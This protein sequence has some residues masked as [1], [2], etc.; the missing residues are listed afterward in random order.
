MGF[1]LSIPDPRPEHVAAIAWLNESS[2][3]NRHACLAPACVM[4]FLGLYWT[5]NM[6]RR[7]EST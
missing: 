6:W 3:A 1:V 4:D 2:S 7:G 5:I